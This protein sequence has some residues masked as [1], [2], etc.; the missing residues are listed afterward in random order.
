MKLQ[1]VKTVMNL[2]YALCLALI[3]GAFLCIKSNLA[4]VFIGGSAVVA[5]I[6]TIFRLKFWRCP[7]CGHTL[8]KGA[9]AR[10]DFC[11]W[12]LRL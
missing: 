6:Q 9:S 11:K 8:S 3:A 7:K 10:C 1:T 4:Y 5:T 12:E 2:L